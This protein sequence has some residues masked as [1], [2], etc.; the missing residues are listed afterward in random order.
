MLASGTGETLFLLHEWLENW[1]RHFGNGRRLAIFLARREGRLVAALP[2]ME[3]RERLHGLPVVTLRS[4]TNPHS[5]R[6]N[7]LCGTGDEPAMEAIWGCLARRARPWHA[8]ILEDVPSDAPL[9]APMLRA[10]ARDRAPIGVWH[11]G[12]V[13]YLTVEGTW[14]AYHATLSQKFRANL[15]RR[16]SR[17]LEQGEVGYRRITAPEEV[18]EALRAG[19]KLEGSG[20]K[21]EE[22]SS[23]ASDPNLIRFYDRWAQIAAS[24]GWLAL[25]FLDVGGVPV[26]F[27]YSTCHE[28]RYYNMKIGYDPAWARYSVGQLLKEEILRRC[29]ECGV[30]EYDFLGVTSTSKEDWKPS[31]RGH[32]WYFVYAPRPLG[33]LLHFLK[34]TATPALKRLTQ[35]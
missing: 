17:L 2:L 13:P 15:R 23:I 12:R 25:S 28:G 14:E 20:W 21:D 16:R 29:F 27:D 6:F 3:Q 24:K 31:H 5:C 19:L 22:G 32:D 34:F 30:S 9:L 4:M 11:G 10:A 35:R 7:A 18:P 33:R 8:M 1:W 26:A